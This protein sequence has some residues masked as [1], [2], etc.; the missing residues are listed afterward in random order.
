MQSIAVSI[1]YR[2]RQD[3]YDCTLQIER[4]DGTWEDI[5]S[6]LPGWVGYVDCD[7]MFPELQTPPERS[8]NPSDP[9]YVPD[10]AAPDWEE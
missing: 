3:A 8:D 9:G 5:G 1:E 2:I 7:E 10:W 6:V 4:P